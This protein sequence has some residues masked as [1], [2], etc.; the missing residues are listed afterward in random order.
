MNKQSAEYVGILDVSDAVHSVRSL[1]KLLNSYRDRC[2]FRS[3][4]NIWDGS[5]Y[6]KNNAWVGAHQKFFRARWGGR[7][8]LELGHFHKNFVKNTR[9]RDPAGNRVYFPRYCWNYILN[10]KFKPKMDTIEAFLSEIRHFLWFLKRQG[11]LPLFP[12][13]AR[14]W[15][16]LN[17]HQYLWISL[18][19][20]ENA[21]INCSDCARALNMHD[22]PTCSIGFWRCLGL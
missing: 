13:V 7:R 9:K 10:G 18:N 2:V 4:S 20:L 15:V 3:S 5:F 8:F 14:L 6:K 1:Y 11:K 21:W 16:W 12:L 19:I 22:H 17:M